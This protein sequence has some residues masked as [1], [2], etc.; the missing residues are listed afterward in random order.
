TVFAGTIN[1]SGSLEI[2]TTKAYTETTI[3]KII[4]LVEEAQS[5]KAPSQRFEDVVPRYYTPS[6]MI[7][8]LLVILAPPLLFHGAWLTWF[9]RGLVLLV[10]ACPCALVIS[11][12]V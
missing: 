9:Y 7:A 6:V 4:H 8:A 3:A 1:G 10:I 12:P 2:Q 11:T 5:K